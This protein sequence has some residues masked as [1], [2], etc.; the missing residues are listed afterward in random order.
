MVAKKMHRKSKKQQ[1]AS[2]KRATMNESVRKMYG[3]KP[4]SIIEINNINNR[5]EANR[6]ERKAK[7]LKK[8]SKKKKKKTSKK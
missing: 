7:L 5:M 6:M 4:N 1:K 8:L 3:N 2:D